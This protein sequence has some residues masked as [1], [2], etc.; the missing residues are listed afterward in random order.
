[1]SDY[2][3]FHGKLLLPIALPFD[4]GTS[5]DEGFDR[6]FEIS[7]SDPTGGQVVS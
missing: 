4:D 2:S 6:L 5:F 1:M 3:V 7:S